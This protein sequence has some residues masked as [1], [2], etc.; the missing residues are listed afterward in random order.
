ML[1]CYYH[2]RNDVAVDTSNIMR[3]YIMLGKS[4]FAFAHDIPV[5]NALEIITTEKD[6]DWSFSNRVYL[7]LAHLHQSMSY[8]KIGKLEIFRLPSLSG[9]SRWSN[10]KGYVSSERK[11]QCFVVNKCEGITDIINLNM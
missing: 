1:D 10:G 3:K 6:V 5:K 11:V 7:I 2:G 9:M 4:M 8:E